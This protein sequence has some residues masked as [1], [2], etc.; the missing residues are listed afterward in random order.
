[1][2][3]YKVS[4]NI[5]DMVYIGQTIRLLERRWSQHCSKNM[6]SYLSRA[7]RKYGKENFRIEIIDTA[8]TIEELNEK[9]VYW[10]A[11][12]NCIS[13]I[14]YNLVTGGSNCFHSEETKLKRSKSLTGKKRKP[15]TEEHLQNLRKAHLG[16]KAS[17]ESIDK[18]TKSVIGR[19]QS[20]ETKMKIRNKLMG[21]PVSESTKMK[22]KETKLKKQTAAIEKIK[23]DNNLQ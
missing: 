23:R 7:I 12:Y 9:E 3:I 14:W 20:E 22:I 16:K 8:Q 15:F 17:Q 5:N 10:I 6:D 18:R 21:H 19:K 11:F 1:M 2:V 4:N 13:P